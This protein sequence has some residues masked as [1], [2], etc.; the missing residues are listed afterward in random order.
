ME[1]LQV[2]VN[3]L[4]VF[5]A[6]ILLY[7]TCVDP[8]NHVYACVADV[9]SRHYG[10]PAV[11]PLDYVSSAPTKPYEDSYGPVPPF[12]DVDASPRRLRYYNYV[13]NFAIGMSL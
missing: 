6:F 10:S 12:R 1:A 3:F 7:F 9:Y 4:Q 2:F 5:A 11:S 8:F 13:V